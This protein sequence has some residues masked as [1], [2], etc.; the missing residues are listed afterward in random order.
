[1]F[2][3]KYTQ[4][5]AIYFMKT[6]DQVLERFKQYL[7]DMRLKEDDVDCVEYNVDLLYTDSDSLFISE[8]FK[9]FCTTNDI[10][11]FVSAPYAHAH[12]GTI[13]REMRTIG[14]AAISLLHSAGMPLSLWDCAYGYAVYCKNRVYTQVHY[15]EDHRFKVPHEVGSTNE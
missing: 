2:K 3:D 9:R 1:M 6:K 4:H 15:C 8:A 10:T 12:N 5:R 11:R 14:E 13:E 7:V